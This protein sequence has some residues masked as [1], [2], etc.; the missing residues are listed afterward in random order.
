M[1]FDALHKSSIQTGLCAASGIWS[2]A[3]ESY[4]V[5]KWVIRCID[6]NMSEFIVAGIC[7]L[8][9]LVVLQSLWII[10]PALGALAV[11]FC[12][13]IVVAGLVVH[14]EKAVESWRKA[15]QAAEIFFQN[16]INGLCSIIGD[17]EEL[18]KALQGTKESLKSNQ[19]E[20]FSLKN[21][22]AELIT[23][24]YAM[25]GF[26]EKFKQVPELLSECEAIENLFHI[27]EEQ[28]SGINTDLQTGIQAM[29]ATLQE[30]KGDQMVLKMLALDTLKIVKRID[31]NTQP[32]QT[33]F[34][35]V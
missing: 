12:V 20:V 14:Q 11:C 5:C 30:M 15:A 1:F 3:E 29:H 35:P 18:I 32:Q 22:I 19:E 13:I 4:L 23:L 25:H 21:Q 27:L 16:T 17:R 9:A 31:V 34:I 10:S 2:V 6:P 28:I 26:L 7:S 8:T 24:S 33:S